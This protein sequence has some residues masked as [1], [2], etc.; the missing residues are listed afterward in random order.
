MTAKF[1]S[2][3]FLTINVAWFAFWIIINLD[4]IPGIKPFD[5]FP[6]GLLTMVVSLE[7]IVLAIV[8]LISQNRGA[9][10]ADLR[11]E[12]DLQ[13]DIIT[14]DEITKLMKM[15]SLF[16]KKQGIDTS[17]DEELQ[18]MLEPTNL[19]NIEEVLGQQVADV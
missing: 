9:R 13:V 16:L 19:S 12:I 6:F 2:V 17:S 3:A 10:L 18:Q 1:G 11:E 4:L 14:E 8:V 15:M 5:P 7:A